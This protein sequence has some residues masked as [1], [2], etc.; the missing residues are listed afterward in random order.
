MDYRWY[1]SYVKLWQRKHSD[2]KLLAFFELQN[3]SFVCKMFYLLFLATFKALDSV[4][5]AYYC[6]KSFFW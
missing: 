6:S 4:L 5:C 3:K 1:L 2:D